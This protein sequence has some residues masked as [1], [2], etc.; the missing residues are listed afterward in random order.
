MVCEISDGMPTLW[1]L[2]FTI[3]AI[4]IS[5][6]ITKQAIVMNPAAATIPPITAD[7]TDAGRETVLVLAVLGTIG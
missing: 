3:L 4:I 1:A 7:E 6:V 5:D 2:F